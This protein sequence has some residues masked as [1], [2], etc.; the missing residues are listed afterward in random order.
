[1]KINKN[2]KSMVKV[3]YKP[4]VVQV[5]KVWLEESVAETV[6]VSA[7]ADLYDWEVEPDPIEADDPIEITLIN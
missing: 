7:R 5:T 3:S 6:C 2:K 1:M 4:P